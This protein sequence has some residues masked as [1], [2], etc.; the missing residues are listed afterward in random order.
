MFENSDSSPN[1]S[2]FGSQLFRWLTIA[3]LA[4]GLTLGL[5]QSAGAES[6][7]AAQVAGSSS[8]VAGNSWTL[9]ED[10]SANAPSAAGAAAS[11]RIP[12]SWEVDWGWPVTKV[13][14]SPA[15]QGW[16]LNQGGR[17]VVRAAICNWNAAS[18]LACR[19]PWI[20]PAI[21]KL[22]DQITNHLKRYLSPCWIEIQAHEGTINSINTRWW[23]Q[24]QPR[25]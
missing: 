13:R 2:R 4:L 9:R 23:C 25:P 1:E 22:A 20:S 12:G 14:I 17:A 21:N 15:R 16:I 11:A 18:K 19:L 5:T 7:N 3:T 24:G 10:L 6:S 8:T